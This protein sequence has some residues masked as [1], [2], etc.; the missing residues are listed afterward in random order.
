MIKSWYNRLKIN[1]RG[2]RYC[3]KKYNRDCLR[4]QTYKDRIIIFSLNF[5]I[6]MTK[7]ILDIKIRIILGVGIINLKIRDWAE[8]QKRNILVIEI[9]IIE[10]N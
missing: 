10:R 2:H 1:N 8:E 9:K 6:L 5:K 4:S 3:N 7:G